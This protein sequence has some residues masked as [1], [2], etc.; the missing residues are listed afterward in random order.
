MDVWWLTCEKPKSSVRPCHHDATDLNTRLCYRVY[1]F[2][3]LSW[4]VSGSEK[5]ILDL[6][7]LYGIWCT[8]AYGIP[9][10][11]VGRAVGPS[12]CPR[13]L[14]VSLC[15]SI[16]TWWPTHY[17]WCLQFISWAGLTLCWRRQD[18]ISWFQTYLGSGSVIDSLFGDNI[19]MALEHDCEQKPEPKL[20]L[21]SM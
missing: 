7:I 11:F 18:L 9:M 2:F 8:E 20:P 6:P 4:P 19:G 14:N 5:E 17:G 13:V 16:I 3:F 15:S 12:C 10:G 1:N 21:I